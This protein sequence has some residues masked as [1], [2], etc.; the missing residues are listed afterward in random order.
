MLRYVFA[1]TMEFADII[2]HAT[3][4]QACSHTY[5]CYDITYKDTMRHL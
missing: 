1:L 4:S 2:E 3:W 5:S